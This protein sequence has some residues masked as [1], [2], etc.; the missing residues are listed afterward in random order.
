MLTDVEKSEIDKELTHYPT[1]QAAC[2]E[3]LKVVQKHRRWVSDASLRD[4]AHY[5]DMPVQELD[6]VATFY[7]LIFRAPVGRHVIL[8]C[9]SISCFVMGYGNLYAE[10]KRRLGID[11]GQTTADGRFTL[12]PIVCLGTCDH[13]PALMVDDDLHRDLTADRISAILDSYT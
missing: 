7:N 12:L 13:A 9:N 3:A 8:L 2:L 10:L 1:K 5:L 11:F 6:S 4:V